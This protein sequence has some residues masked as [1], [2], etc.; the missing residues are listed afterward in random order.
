[1]QVPA[2]TVVDYIVVGASSAGNVIANKLSE[3]GRALI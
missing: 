1:M 3:N 2:D